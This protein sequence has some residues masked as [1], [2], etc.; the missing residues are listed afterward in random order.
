MLPR[1]RA[2]IVKQF[3]GALRYQQR[4]AG[5]VRAR[6]LVLAVLALGAA[7]LASLPA[8]SRPAPASAEG[9]PTAQVWFAP[10]PLG[11]PGIPLQDGFGA[12]DF[13][14]L[15]AE[16]APWETAASRLGVFKFYFGWVNDP[17]ADVEAAVADLVR[18]G[19]AIAIEVPALRAQQHC[20]FAP[21]EGFVDDPVAITRDAVQ[22]IQAAGGTVAA[23]VL[24]EPYTFA[25]PGYT[26]PGACNWSA[27][28][29][30][31]HVRT[32]FVEGVRALFPGIP[33][34]VVENDHLSPAQ[35]DAWMAAWEAVVGEPFAFYHLDVD[36]GARSTWTGPARQVES[37]ARARNIPFG[38]IYNGLF[39]DSSNQQWIER[40]VQHMGRYES[41]GGGRP[42]HVIFQSWHRYPNRVLPETDPTAMTSLI[43]RYF[44]QR[45]DVA[46][47]VDAANTT[48]QVTLTT[49]GQ[50]VVGAPVELTAT[51]VDGPGIEQTFTIA[52]VVPA[53]ATHAVVG[54]RVNQECGCGGTGPSYFS[55]YQVTYAQ[56][57]ASN[58]PQP[59]GST[60][61]P[62]YIQGTPSSVVQF[63][64]TSPRHIR[65]EAPGS[66]PA[67]LNSGLI[68]LGSSPAGKPFTS[69]FRAKVDP[70]TQHYGY[71]TV[72]F[73][74]YQNNAYSE[75]NRFRTTIQPQP[76][77]LSGTTGD[78][79]VATIPLASLPPARVELSGRY[80]G[81]GAYWPAY[82]G[83]Q[84]IGAPVPAITSITP[85]RVA[86]GGPVS[87]NLVVRGA[88]LNHDSIIQV[89]GVN[90]PTTF[91]DAPNVA[92]PQLRTPL[93]L[94]DAA[95]GARQVRVF[96]P[97]PGGGMSNVLL[98]EA[99]P[100]GYAAT[101]ATTIDEGATYSLH[102]SANAFP[103][104]DAIRSWR[105]D[106]GD[107]TVQKFC[108]LASETGCSAGFIA[109]TGG[110]VTHRYGDGP[111]VYRIMVS[112]HEPGSPA[113]DWPSAGSINVTVN[114]VPPAV[115]MNGPATI[116]EGSV[117]TL[118]LGAAD[119][120][121]DTITGW[122]VDWGDGS[123]PVEAPAG[124]ATFTHT[125]ADGPAN[126]TIRAW[127]RDEDV[128]PDGWHPPAEKLVTVTDFPPTL[129]VNGAASTVVG[130]PYTI[131]FAVVADP[132]DDT[133]SGWV[134]DWG[135][136]VVD[137]LG[138]DAVEAVHAFSAGA[139]IRDVRVSAVDED[140]T[141]PADVIR[142]Q[143]FNA[144][145]DISIQGDAQT[146]EGQ[147]YT[148]T[149][150][151][152]GAGFI[153]SWT[154]HWGD[155]TP[156]QVIDGNPSSVTHAF[157]DGPA[158]HTV[159]AT[160]TDGLST[161]AA[162]SI[163]VTV[164][165]I[166]P[167]F[168][169]AGPPSVDEG[170]TYTLHLAHSDPGTD[171]PLA[172]R[173][174][175]GDGTI[176]TVTGNPSSLAHVYADGP[177]AHVI[178][179]VVIDRH[180]E[181][182]ASST[183]AVEVLDVEPVVTISGPASIAEGA[184]YTLDLSVVDPGD[185]LVSG[186]TIDWGDGVVEEL[187]GPITAATHVYPNGPASH[188]ISAVAHG[189]TLSWPARSTVAVSVMDVPPVVTVAGPA[190]V[191]EQNPF[192]ITLGAFDPAD[193]V[194]GITVDWGDGT[195]QELPGGA[196]EATHT[197]VSGP[198]TYL[199]RVAAA[200]ADGDGEARHAIIVLGPPA[201]TVSGPATVAEGSTYV[202]TLGASPAR[203]TGWT[204]DWGDGSEPEVVPGTATRAEHVYAD[205]PASWTIRV[206]AGDGHAAWDAGSVEVTVLDVAP[207]GSLA[208]PAT[209][210]A[211]M[212]I[213]V[214]LI[215][216]DPGHDP[217]S[218]WTVDWGDGSPPETITAGLSAT[219]AYAS[220]GE[221]RV[222]ASFQD[223]DGQWTATPLTVTVGA[224]APTLT[225]SG[226]PDVDEGA[227]Y[228]LTLASNRPVSSWV[229]DWGDGSQ[230]ETLDGSAMS[231]SHTYADG[232]ASHVIAAMAIDA[233]GE[234][235][236]PGL[237]VTVADVAPVASVTGTGSTAATVPYT[238]ALVSTD[239]GDDPV[240]AWMIDWGDG[241][242]PQTIPGSATSATHVYALPG[243][244]TIVATITNGDGT[245]PAAAHG[246]AVSPPP[247]PRI[248]GPAEV[249]SGAPYVLDLSLEDYPE[250]ATAT[251]WVVNWG[252]G[253]EHWYCIRPFSHTS[254]AGT[255]DRMR[256]T[257]SHAYPASD[258]SY[259][260]TAAVHNPGSSVAEWPPAGDIDVRVVVVPP[261][262]TATGA[263]SVEEGALYALTLTA[264]RPMISWTI[265]WG[266]GTPPQ[267]VPGGQALVTHVFADGPASHQ[268]MVSATD[269][270]GTWQVGAPA[271]EVLDV[272]PV[273]AV[274]GSGSSVPGGSYSVALTYT[275]PGDDPPLQWVIDWG[276]GTPPAT[277]GGLAGSASHSYS[278]AGQY[279]ITATVANGAGPW[280]AA[281]HTVTVAAPPGPR[282]S[283]LPTVGEG[284]LY[285]VHLSLESYEEAATA[286]RWVVKWGNG[287]E[288]WFC[289][290]P[291][292]HSSCIGSVDRLTAT[293][294]YRY[295]LGG[296]A[297]YRILASVHNPTSAR[298]WPFAGSI[299][300]SV[301]DLPPT[302]SVS[303][304]AA[305][306]QGTTY[307]A[308]FLALDPGGDV[309]THWRVDWGDGSPEQVVAGAS[310]SVPHSY[311]GPAG[312]TY[313][314]RAWARDAHNPD[315]WY[316]PVEHVITVTN[317]PPPATGQLQLI[318][319]GFNQPVAAAGSPDGTNRL[320]VAEK[321]GRIRLSLN[322]Q[323]SSTPFLDIASRVRSTGAE[324]G[325]LG[326]AFHPDFPRT[327]YVYVTY[328]AWTRYGLELRLSRFTL[329]SSNRDRANPSSERVLF[330]LAQPAGVNIGGS[331]A[332][333]PGP[334]TWLYLALGDGGSS[335]VAQA[336]TNRLGKVLRF[337]T[338]LSSPRA[339]IVASGLRNPHGIAWDL[340]AGRLFVPD[341]GVARVEEVSLVPLAQLPGAN[342]GWDRWEGTRCHPEGATCPATTAPMTQHVIAE[343][344]RT[345]GCRVRGGS[346]YRGT[347]QPAFTEAF[348]YADRCSG[349][350]WALR[351]GPGG[352][353]Q[354]QQ[355]LQSSSLAISAIGTDHRGELV[356]VDQAG[357]AVYWLRQQ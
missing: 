117:Y 301:L 243:S 110:T 191:G 266:D 252:D 121:A 41:E 52:G 177:S 83:G 90:R 248:S 213:T 39:N 138:P 62:Y 190:T 19:I 91:L 352:A 291:F 125:F 21:A 142:V 32:N 183:V 46:I 31:T 2:D 88:G 315:G 106:W 158:T 162:P 270:T 199:I 64:S 302:L 262:L 1:E 8:S 235:P 300:L 345:L 89:D 61:P 12:T 76:I 256:A 160:A 251:R 45:T 276:D 245:F 55:L 241:A 24:Q 60:L 73:L 280:S 246:V 349:R 267:T 72:V 192:V 327:P 306:T 94:A 298:P 180:G 283:G 53:Q 113:G 224:L 318:Q 67:L 275:D 86:E 4:P 93:T 322:G 221:R 13:A 141:H 204:V 168:V 240:V 282:I 214:T 70:R 173:V 236:A 310:P 202:L 279:I 81:G 101:G 339:E 287:V 247:M 309:V 150:D 316:G 234:W 313:T 37:F 126:H 277:V 17:N 48:A 210:I 292:T 66:Q 206:A 320:F 171:Q 3:V 185:D 130:E 201:F 198:A 348:F 331:L 147:V 218:S 152:S 87:G 82:A 136:G 225:V 18:R 350:I 28:Q 299:D 181:W 194:T 196:A 314:L 151:A 71:F 11:M 16:G 260:I 186:W 179:A 157:A 75:V 149:I 9:P 217:V 74:R 129:H 154:I 323:V 244:F 353:W 116:A 155:G 85:A 69:T 290:R 170:S 105:V 228:T 127:A 79:G 304:A 263:R 100:R 40:A 176:E 347:L 145:P 51:P 96:T 307:T 254:C 253:T 47:T 7:A 123:P 140:G 293:V 286:T 354:S 296:P 326:M 43:N 195:V 249:E 333:G 220:P 143:V 134:V 78:T 38:I 212:P 182:P 268:L 163:L 284:S 222:T 33:I 258:T 14:A 219:H 80:A 342:L 311:P 164:R 285:T 281:G 216:V 231:A 165:D 303:S 230:P 175:W 325:L 107:G 239:P 104:N 346:Y 265:D 109:P 184:L 259:R 188:T 335:S 289:I 328:T 264:N 312:S 161:W 317:A 227:P 329:N 305:V 114:D 321:A 98:L 26:G 49:G 34:G 174:D 250:A 357:G 137:T 27:T 92:V 36:W 319:A 84:P 95:P 56:Q 261:V 229:I 207:L 178:S 144:P 193:P 54:F 344:D 205:G 189:G 118:T 242:P 288:H 337:N 103:G 44:G 6:A 200:T 238:V 271:I 297:T 148:L 187:S 146:D 211:G 20:G 269:E 197:Y 324:E 330:R 166:P 156:A 132:G 35:A 308:R 63:V 124:T 120:G 232:P 102:L 233:L 25:G 108:V 223:G 57:G 226:R 5:R 340:A 97:G 23:L 208:G 58:L 356:V 30:A 172:W 257:V 111:N 332:F 278:S 133:V 336:A 112:V 131:T 343:Y 122:K 29:T 135:D 295:P 65:V 68:N 351:Q 294:T 273:A 50:P 272:P 341:N 153:T 159:T 115:V 274:T 22:R 10:F 255:V 334:G 59:F 355:L 203:V 42:D 99:V 15:F 209:A 169:I 237:T 338:A 77:A 128:A 119:P 139:I 167:T 215:V